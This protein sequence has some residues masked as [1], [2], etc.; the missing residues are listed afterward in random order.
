MREKNILLKNRTQCPRS[1][2]EPRQ[3]DLEM[4]ALTIM[5]PR[6]L[7]HSNEYFNN[8]FVCLFVCFSQ[9]R[10]AESGPRV[11]IYARLATSIGGTTVREE[12]LTR[13]E[14]SP[15]PRMKCVV[16]GFVKATFA[17]F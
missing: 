12:V 11:T 15:L 13:H 5:S 14:K 4:S 8:N 3:L 9:E 2:P 17:R 6:L 16:K 10:S 1:A 7:G